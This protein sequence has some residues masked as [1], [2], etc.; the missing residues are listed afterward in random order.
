MSLSTK[1]R[2]SLIF[3]GDEPTE[4]IDDL[5]LRTDATSGGGITALTSGS[6]FAATLP[7]ARDLSIRRSSSPTAHAAKIF[8]SGEDCV[9]A[10]TS[11][12]AHSMYPSGTSWYNQLLYFPKVITRSPG[13]CT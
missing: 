9:F 5:Q 6:S 11:F 3:A 8:R 13:G 4:D 2:L 7:L 1:E 12:T 10:C